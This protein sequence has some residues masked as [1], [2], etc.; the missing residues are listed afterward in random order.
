MKKVDSYMYLGVI[1]H[2][3]V[4]SPEHVDTIKTKL[5]KTIGVVYKTGYF[6]NEKSLYLI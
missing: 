2:S 3:K 6:V 4:N 5:L 1:I